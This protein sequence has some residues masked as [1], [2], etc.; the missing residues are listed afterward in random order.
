M[1]AEAKTL[2]HRGVD[3]SACQKLL[4]VAVARVAEAVAL[5]LEAHPRSSR[6]AVTCLART[7]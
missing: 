4:E 1:T 6:L 5:Q 7:L 3:I 2:A